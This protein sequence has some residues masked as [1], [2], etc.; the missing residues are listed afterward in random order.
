[1][2]PQDTQSRAARQTGLT[3]KGGRTVKKTPDP[4][5]TLG[6]GIQDVASGPRTGRGE[7]EAPAEP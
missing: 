2:D 4:F 5:L 6:F 3:G 7:G 1:M